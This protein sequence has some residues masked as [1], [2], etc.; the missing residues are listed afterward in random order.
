MDASS[1]RSCT[2][3]PNYIRIIMAAVPKTTIQVSDAVNNNDHGAIII[4][5]AAV[6]LVC[7]CLFVILRMWMRW[8]WKGLVG[9]DDICTCVAQVRI[10]HVSIIDTF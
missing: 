8:P 4:S 7:S 5:V 3:N 2:S 1:D 6:L 9:A 10:H